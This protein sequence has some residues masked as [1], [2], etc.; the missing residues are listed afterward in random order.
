MSLTLEAIYVVSSVSAAT[1]NLLLIELKSS[2]KYS[3]VGFKGFL[4]IYIYT[5]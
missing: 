4:E 2:K 5:V 3:Y 1:C